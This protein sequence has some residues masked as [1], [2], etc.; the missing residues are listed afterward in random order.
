[1]HLTSTLNP[2]RQG[3]GLTAALGSEPA[4]NREAATSGKQAPHDGSIPTAPCRPWGVGGS[5]VAA[6]LGLSPFRSAVDVWLDKVNHGAA[7]GIQGSKSVVAQRVGTYL[8]PFVV[9]EYERL[10]GN[11]CQPH[12]QPLHHPEYPELFGHVDRMV[13]KGTSHNLASEAQEDAPRVVLEC[14]TC[15][16]FRAGEW[17]PAWG[18]Q[19]PPEYL[20]QCLWYLG[21]AGCEEA[22]L[23]VL[24]G[25]TELRVY[26]ITRDPALER[27]LFERAHRFWQE[28]VL[29]ARPP[30]QKTREEVESLYPSHTPGLTHEAGPQLLAT[31]RRLSQLQEQLRA[32]EEELQSLRHQLALEM[33]AAES[34]TWGGHTIATWRRARD[35][36]RLDTQRLRRELPEVAQAYTR[37]C[38]TGRRLVLTPQAILP[39][40]SPIHPTSRSRHEE[41]PQSQQHSA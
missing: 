37:Q 20:V 4:T 36:A 18:D 7:P 40:L 8:E 9:Q 35:S 24:L 23:A 1:M 19:V 14:K 12:P 25:N 29:T 31:V 33:G 30:P 17:G 6:I 2:S 27:E 16:A 10:T 3:A 28:H 39:N 5:D 15:S 11:T 41:N 22:H 34:L 38:P 21:L 26:R 32:G 13:T